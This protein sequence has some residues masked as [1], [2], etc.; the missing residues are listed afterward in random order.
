MTSDRDL[1]SLA[2]DACVFGVP[3]VHKMLQ[4]DRF[5]TDGVN[6]NP[7]A[8]W[9]T[10]SH[11]SRLATFADGFQSLN[12]DVLYSLAQIDLSGGPLELVLPAVSDRYAGF[13]FVDSWTNVFGYAGRRVDGMSE[14]RFLLTPPGWQGTVPD[15]LEEVRFPTVIGS[16]LG[17]LICRD[18]DDVTRVD[19]VRAKISL[20]PADPEPT[21]TGIPKPTPT[22]STAIDFFERLRVWSTCCPPATRRQLSVHRSFAPLGLHDQVPI[23]ERSDGERRILAAGFE[24]GQ[25][26]IADLQRE[27]RFVP[28]RHWTTPLHAFDF[29]EPLGRGTIDESRWFIDDLLTALGARAVTALAGPWGNHGYEAAYYLTAEDSSGTPLSGS[30]RYTLTLRSELSAA[31]H[32]S[33]TMY[34]SPGYRLVDAPNN[35]H[36][37]GTATR[38]VRRE[39][40]GSV[41]ISIQQDTPSGDLARNWLPAPPGTFRP[42]LRLYAPGPELL[43]ADEFRP[44][45]LVRQPSPRE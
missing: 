15:A 5:V 23:S 10:F 39:A 3:L 25:E 33:L 22:G 11:A 1:I 6:L 24:Q 44:P 27:R 19:T 35:R 4:M 45:A 18:P 8:P 28:V 43:G 38:G 9:N 31:A 17:R 42:I 37:V 34:D 13:Q 2:A 20:R 14:G 29:S 7:P 32:W 16:I 41:T 40:D 36:S 30:E 21:P 26:R 12:N